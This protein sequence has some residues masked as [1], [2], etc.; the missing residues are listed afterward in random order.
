MGLFNQLRS[1]KPTGVHTLEASSSALAEALASVTLRATF[2]VG[3]VS[4]HVDVDKVAQVLKARFAGVPL[5]LCTTAGELCSSGGSLYC[6]TGESWDRVVVQCFDASLVERA[7]VVAL[8]LGSEDLRRGEAQQPLKERIAAI[9][10][11]IERLKVDIEI[12]HRDTLACVMIDGLSLSESFFME[13]LYD[14]GRFPCLFVGGSAGGK[15]DF[16]NTWM[17]DGQRKLDNHALIAFLKV[18]RGVR[19]GVF[20]SQN[21]EATGIAFS[22]IRASLVNRYVSHVIDESGRVVGFVDALCARLH[23]APDGLEKALS[24]YSFAIRV[25]EEL[26]VRSMSRI[27]FEQGRVHFFCDIAP[28]EELLLVKRTGFAESTARD[29]REFMQGKPGAP[30]AGILNDCILR[31]LNNDKALAQAAPIF[32]CR[33]LAG[34]STFGEILGLNLNQTLTAVFF[35]RV[36]AG[37]RFSDNYV[38]NFVAH[39]GEFRAF[40]LRRQIGKLSGLGRVMEQ[41]ISEYRNQHFESAL[42]PEIFDQSMKAVAAGLNEL[43]ATLRQA[44]LARVETA[45]Q[46]DGCARDLYASVEQLNLRVGDQEA[47]VSEASA[48]VNTLSVEAVEA[49]QSAR[50]LAESSTRI[51][52]VVE[53]IQQ[54]SDQTN[55][56]ALNAAIEAARAGEAGRGFAV[57]ADEVRKLAEKTRTSAGEIGNDIS[58]LAASIGDVAAK[59]DRQ[60]VD[61]EAVST[62]LGT[63][64]QFSG[65]SAQTAAHT[66]SVADA[67][68]KLTQR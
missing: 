40:F 48:K 8:P 17:H 31:R 44:E 65:N 47:V 11:S 21:F 53:T 22:V 23:C 52:G 6:R 29:Y 60:S 9:S 54:I 16:R 20:K 51:R 25:G 36:P 28:G 50:E 5:M 61:V 64:E 19:F 49:A 62:M 34:F 67:L 32:D 27:D 42:D 15:L 26:F 33:Q 10:R 68:Q 18:A 37:L 39:Y 56:L 46:L 12:D 38:D 13:A 1:A 2:V 59:I 35:F 4:P 43:G 57:V 41:Q 7:Q 45:Q 3:Y 66:R 58:T 14:S 55:L 24:D 30:V 63:I